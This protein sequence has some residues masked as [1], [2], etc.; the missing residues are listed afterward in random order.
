[1]QHVGRDGNEARLFV[2]MWGIF[3]H[4]NIGGIA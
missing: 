4:G 1:V 3:G 2:G